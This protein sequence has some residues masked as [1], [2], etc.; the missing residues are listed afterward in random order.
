[1]ARGVVYFMDS[2]C[3]DCVGFTTVLGSSFVQKINCVMPETVD[4]Y[5]LRDYV[6]E[7]GQCNGIIFGSLC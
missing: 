1:M 7:C 3:V 4:E 6:S 2:W 5:R